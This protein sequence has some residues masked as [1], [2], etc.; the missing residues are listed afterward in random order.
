MTDL[1]EHAAFAR[2][3]GLVRYRDVRYQRGRRLSVLLI[4]LAVACVRD[5][6]ARQ[7]TSTI[8][9]ATSVALPSAEIAGS[10]L[11]ASPAPPVSTC[12]DIFRV[13]V[14]SSAVRS[15][16]Y[17]A[18]GRILE[19]EFVRGS[20]YRYFGVPERVFHDFLNAPSHGRYLNLVLKPAGYPYRRVQ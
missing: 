7:H 16:G 1:D 2:R 11:A 4:P 9:S 15:I 13:P 6:S 5:Q 17:C 10:E 14:V 20:V 3:L 18:D 8:G 19:V 12:R